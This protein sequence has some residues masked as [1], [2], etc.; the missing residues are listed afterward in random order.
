MQGRYFNARANWLNEFAGEGFQTAILCEPPYWVEACG[1][2]FCIV[3]DSAEN[4]ALVDATRAIND[5]CHALLQEIFRSPEPSTLL[6]L[7]GVL[8][9]HHEA[10][11]LSFERSDPSLTGR[12][13]FVLFDGKVKLLEYNADTPASLY[14]SARLQ[15][16]WYQELYSQGLIEKS[17]F[18][19][20]VIG[21]RLKALLPQIIGAE[22]LHLA[23][24]FGAVEDRENLVF[25]ESVARSCSIKSKMIYMRDIDYDSSGLLI[26]ADGQRIKY[27]YR[28]YPWDVL[29]DDDRALMVSAGLEHLVVSKAVA[30]NTTQFFE[31]AWKC[32]LSSKALLPLLWRLAPGHPNLLPACFDD[33]GAA[34]Q[35]IKTVPHVRKPCFGYSG[36]D[37]SVVFPESPELNENNPERFSG[38]RFILQQYQPLSRFAQHNL[39]IGSWLIGGEPAGFSV[40]ADKRLVTGRDAL[41]VPHYVLP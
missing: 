13:D 8:P 37:V 15:T 27:L 39:V 4:A 24:A 11:R 17:A 34:A 12:L 31:P 9:V 2:P 29:F 16:L 25:M 33:G 36:G 23:S 6:E 18:Q 26:D 21:D 22:V 19:N 5:L 30:D 41:F 28:I 3:F 40:R 14:E 20:N 10:V 7:L 35:A 38:N 1:E 32:L